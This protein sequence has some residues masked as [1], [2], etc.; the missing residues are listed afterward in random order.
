M[1]R[2]LQIVLC[3]ILIL[4]VLGFIFSNSMESIPESRDKSL[5]VMKAI[6]PFL[7]FFVGKGNVTNH[8]VRKLAHFTE[9]FA[10]GVSAGLLWWLLGFHVL[11]AVV[12]TLLAAITDE[13][14]QIFTQRGSQV[15]D[16]WLDFSGAVAGL[17][18][19][20]IVRSIVKRIRTKNV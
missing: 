7:E 16:V 17:V 5:G 9:F 1:K 18:V 12:G 19:L 4:L 20:L 13:T 3:V 2:T 14:I 11:Y 10:L 15:Q 8:M 6:E